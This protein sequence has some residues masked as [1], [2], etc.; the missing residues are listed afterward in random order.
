[1]LRWGS[2]FPISSGLLFSI[3]TCMFPEGILLIF[4]GWKLWGMRFAVGN[5][6]VSRKR[7]L[8]HLLIDCTFDGGCAWRHPGAHKQN[9]CALSN[10]LSNFLSSGTYSWQAVMC[11]E[12]INKVHLLLLFKKIAFGSSSLPLWLALVILLSLSLFL[13]VYVC[14]NNYSGVGSPVRQTTSCTILSLN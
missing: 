9:D 6:W 4:S 13:S 10:F 11:L 1:M 2:H 7:S 14:S 5:Y 8:E 12:G 3:S